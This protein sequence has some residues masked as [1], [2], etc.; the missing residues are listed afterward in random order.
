MEADEARDLIEE[1]IERTEAGDREERS[2][3][4]KFRDRVSVL[5]GV[6]ALSLA[7]IHMAAAGAQRESLLKSIEGSDTFA[8]MQ[9]KVVRETVLNSAATTPGLESATKAADLAE[10]QR[11]RNPDKAGHGIG[12]LQKQGERLREESAAAAA[13]SEGYETGETALQLAIVLLSI[14]LIAQSWPIV[15]GASVLAAAGVG[16]SVL[17]A[18]GLR[19]I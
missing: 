7:L 18:L 11:L 16:V 12:Q 1:A 15:A 17:T 6:F 4:R 14:A 10:A 9:A 3:E 2:V 13:A 5:V 8:Y 19:L